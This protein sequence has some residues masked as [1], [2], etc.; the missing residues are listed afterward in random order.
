MEQKSIFN[1]L[2]KIT[3]SEWIGILLLGICAVLAAM[4][5]RLCF[6]SDIWYDELFTMGL[7]EHTFKE[8][9][10]F[11]ARDVHPPFYYIYVKI[12]QKL[13]KLVAADVNLV[14]V[15]KLCSV[16][17][18]LLLFIYGI[19]KVRKHFG[20]L[21]AGIFTFCLF[22]MPQLSQYTTEIRM[23]SLSLF[24]VTAAF[25]HSYEIA[26]GSRRDWIFLTLY[27]ILAAYTHYFACMAIGM[28]YLYL[29]LYFIKNN[30]WKEVWRKWLLSAAV[31]GIAYI[32]WMFA[33]VSQ[34]SRVK[35]NYWI[36]PLTWRSIGGCVKFL[37]KPSFMNDQWN[38][39]AAVILFCVYGG[40]FLLSFYKDRGKKGKDGQRRQRENM[41]AAAGVFVLTGLVAFG[42]TASFLIRPVFIYRYML[43]A[44][45]CFWL[46]FSILYSRFFKNRVIFIPVLLLL[47]VIGAADYKAFLG[48]ESFKREQM[49]LTGQALE[50]I[51]A[52]DRIIF[53]FNHVQG[54][55]G[56]YLP[57]NETYLWMEEPEELIQE[58]FRN[59]YEV[60]SAEQIKDWLWEGRRV[61]FV[62]SG[63]GREDLIALWKKEQIGTK[64]EA[65]CLIERYWFNLYS[66]YLEK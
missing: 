24:L 48:E 26:C 58:M 65:G 54:I 1:H 36:L 63:K 25:L 23:Y 14:I 9:T 10:G 49:K 52:G 34:V 37:L 66:L 50:E 45:G 53:N 27:G 3:S 21:T 7:S 17:P 30:L 44:M 2:K 15:S 29:L 57:D 20:L 19:T 62:G 5:V 31:S 59:R 43:P 11:T 4:S 64:E 35:E 56:Y 28:I 22:T 18:F 38:V 12:I 47:L 32:P 60:M 33:V 40:I 39:I 8:L 41:F 6:S 42:F 46:C 61:W 13:C 51:A 55:L 16:L